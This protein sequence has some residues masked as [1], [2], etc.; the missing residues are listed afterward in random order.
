MYQ[1][2]VD[3]VIIHDLRDKDLQVIDPKLSLELNKASS[4]QFKILPTHPHFD[5]LKKHKSKIKVYKVYRGVYDLLFEGR[6]LDTDSDFDNSNEVI[7]EGGLAYFLDSQQRPFEFH[8]IS[9]EDFLKYVIGVHNSHVDVDKQFEVGRVTVTGS[10]YR[11]SQKYVDTFE[12]LNDRFINRL[13]GYLN[14]RYEGNKRIVD[15]LKEF[16][17]IS[18]QSIIFGE[19]LLDLRQYAVA[20]D[21][22]TVIIPLGTRLDDSDNRLTIESVNDGKDYLESKSA[23]D[24]YGR[25]EGVV[26][27]E[28]V[29]E[30]INLKKKGE[31]YLE[32]VIKESLVLELNALD[33]GLLDTSIDYLKSG[34]WIRVISKP[35][36][37][38]NHFLINRLELDLSSPENSLITLGSTVKG[39]SDEV[40]NNQRLSTQVSTI[41]DNLNSAVT[42]VGNINQSLNNTITVVE[43]V[44]NDT[45]A[46]AN[47]IN[48]ISTNLINLT[49]EVSAIKDDVNKING[50]LDRLRK[51]IAMEV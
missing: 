1:I 29:T 34:D 4:L 6:F 23:I 30:A 10:L 8:D 50:N 18:S 27:F 32:E 14:I 33:L 2:R 36:K 3:D 41:N 44:I 43:N 35:H 25:I 11:L 22:K 51:R 26:E 15:Y 20:S 24:I 31:D 46:L 37:I 12:I 42:Q 45:T 21:V 48:N 7:C 13:G 47:T 17:G 5:K 49:S 38:A 19:N 40:V 28:D 39:L 9:V 16:E